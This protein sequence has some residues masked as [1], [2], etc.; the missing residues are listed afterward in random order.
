MVDAV[1]TTVYGYDSVGELLGE[2]GPWSSDTVNYTY[3]NRLRSGLAV[4]TPNGAAWL[5]RYN[6]A[7]QRTNVVRTAGDYVNY[8]YDGIGELTN[9]SGL[10]ANGSGRVDEQ[11]GY[12]YDPA[13][14]LIQ[15]NEY[16]PGTPENTVYRIN[17]LNQITNTFFG[18]LK[19]STWI[20]DMVVSG[21]TTSPATNVTV[22]GSVVAAY[23]DNTFA[24]LETVAIGANTFTA[25]AKDVYGRTSTSTSV[26]NVIPTNNAYAY[27]LNGNLLTDGTRHFGY[28]DEN[29]LISVWQ[30][31]AWSNNFVYDG[32]MRRRIERDFTWNAGSSGWL[33][34]NEIHFIYDGNLVV[35]ERDINNQP[36][37]TYT[38]GNDLS[39]KLQG[40]GGI[41]G[42]LARNDRA[43]AIP[44]LS[45][46]GGLSQFGTPSYYRADGNGN[47][48]SVSPHY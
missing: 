39:G 11:R 32:K 19:G 18:V 33:L 7:S 44:G 43:Q 37:V 46:F 6:R 30:V 21:S 41:G 26:V 40:A 16:P 10:Q 35:Q 45:A 42:L 48:A 24:A 29:Q 9:A 1:G 3:Q 12:L 34:T 17:R 47:G 20:G 27:D 38:R 4:Q 2:D 36:Q 8:A 25:V 5:W 15:K 14:N 28:D 23:S 13:G 31:N 22:N